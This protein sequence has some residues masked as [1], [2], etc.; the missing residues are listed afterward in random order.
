MYFSYVENYATWREKARSF[1]QANIAPEK[2]TW[3]DKQQLQGELFND[4]VEPVGLFSAKKILVPKSFFKLAEMVS[5]H[6]DV[7]KWQKLYE[8]LWRLTHG[9][10]NLL[11]ISSDLLVNELALLAKSVGRDAHKMKAF[12]RFRC[13]EEN[14]KKFYIAW[15]QPDH[16]I[17][18][19]VAPFFVRRFGTMDWLIVTPY[20]TAMWDGEQLSFLPGQQKFIH[21]QE[22][23][24]NNLWRTYYRAIFN[25]ARIKIKAMLREMP[26]RYWH[27]LPETQ[28]ITEILQEA[29]SRVANMLKYTE[30]LVN[31][32]LDYFPDVIDL[33]NLKKAS[34]QC[35]A[36][37]IHGCAKQ[38]VFGRGSS[39]AKIVIVGEQP[40]SQENEQGLPLIGPSGQYLQKILLNLNID[41]EEIYFTNAIKHFKHQVIDSRIKYQ[42]PTIKEINACKPWLVAEIELI[43]P[44]IIICLGL[45]AAKSLVS[46]GF[47]FKKQR[48]KWQHYKH[49]PLLV[50]YHP[51]AIL[52]SRDDVVK[53]EL[54]QLFSQ[55]IKT[56]LE[57]YN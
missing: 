10:K 41:L 19:K 45:V 36:C 48:G 46:H 22:D 7:I 2:I 4:S 37:P 1:L 39:K 23:D 31:S 17:I 21:S 44:K 42:T 5:L 11:A 24:F 20:E 14:S 26:V 15:Y 53:A 50:T 32:A 43:Q 30:G 38:T 9:E 27:N 51:A 54:T 12:I 25:P 47:H 13:Y 33:E 6:N 29:P 57:K 8:A 28:V 56:A 18:R 55:D 40:G 34:M 16:N 3:L 35:R 52:R 49:I